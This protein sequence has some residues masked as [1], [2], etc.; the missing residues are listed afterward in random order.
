MEKKRI[1]EI[2]VGG[3]ILIILGIFPLVYHNF[4]FDILETKYQFYYIVALIMLVS[5]LGVVVWHKV[6]KTGSTTNKMKITIS[7]GA[8]LVFLFAAILSTVFSEFQY[9]AFWGN[10]GRLTG[11]FLLS[12][13]VGT[14]FCIRKFWKFRSWFL[15]VFLF[16][17]MLACLFG[18]T[19]YF[20][21]DLL[22]FKELMQEEQK[23]MFVSTFGNINTY[24]AYAAMVLSVSTVLYTTSKKM[25]WTIVYYVCMTISFFALI[26]GQSDN[27]YLALGALVGLL[28]LWLA[29]QRNGIK[30]FL[31]TLSTYFTVMQCIDIINQ[32]MAERVIGLDGLFYAVVN[33]EGLFY[34]M[35]ALWILTA[36]VYARSHFH[37]TVAAKTGKIFRWCWIAMLV[38]AFLAVSA[39][40]YDVNVQGNIENYGGLGNYLLFSDSWGSGRGAIWR[41]AVKDFKEFTL[42]QKLFGYGPETFGIL[43]L[44][45]N[46]KEMWEIAGVIY[47]NAHNEYLQ[48]L[49]TIGWVGLLSYLVFIGSIIIRGF[50]RASDKPYVIAILFALISYWAQALVNINLPLVAPFMWTF[51]AMVMVGIGQENECENETLIQEQD[52]KN[53]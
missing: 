53:D 11:L 16:T 26:T 17:G 48:Y 31:V 12:I 5:L 1:H 6:K 19:H 4:Y 46:K 47:D 39:V 13:Y 25:K 29:S 14:Y 22:G 49:V 21:M 2:I 51:A 9:E 30:R 32:K 40:L 33:Y 42:F 10:E 3:F 7:D 37:E 36:V 23:P 28:P 34:V 44:M 52:I 18:I 35:I 27:A 8:L 50:K 41:F 45:K 20:N 24:T 43:T 38:L 15:N